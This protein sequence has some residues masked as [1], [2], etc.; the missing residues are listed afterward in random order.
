MEGGRPR[1]PYARGNTRRTAARLHCR[2]GRD[3]RAP[4]GLRRRDARRRGYRRGWFVYTPTF[5]WQMP[6]DPIWSSS[7]ALR[8]LQE[9]YVKLA[10]M[11]N[12]LC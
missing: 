6:P 12:Q 7:T 2:G 3:G 4:R 8:S 11:A 1:P 10:A 5:F 9:V